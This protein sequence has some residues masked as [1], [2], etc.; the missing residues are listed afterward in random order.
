VQSF[1]KRLAR[2][3]HV[4]IVADRVPATPKGFPRVPLRVTCP[5]HERPRGPLLEARARL[6][7]IAEGAGLVD[8]ATL[9]LRQGLRRRLLGDWSND[10]DEGIVDAINR[11]EPLL[12]RPRFLALDGVERCDEAT[13]HLLRRAVSSPSWLRLPLLLVFRYVPTE[14][15]AAALAA[16]LGLDPALAVASTQEVPVEGLLTPRAALVLRAAA[17]VGPIFDVPAV[18]RLVGATPLEVLV[19][20]Q[21][22]VDAGFPLQDEADGRL[23]MPPE[24]ARDLRHGLLPSLRKAWG[25]SL[26]DSGREPAVTAHPSPAREVGPPTT[27]REAAPGQPAADVAPDLR[28]V[29]IEK[30]LQEAREAFLEGRDRKAL[31]LAARAV[32]NLEGLPPTPQRRMLRIE[33]YADLAQYK[34][35]SSGD[36]PGTRLADALV[37]AQGAEELLD[38]EDPVD[39]AAGVHA[40]VGSLCYDLGDPESL[41]TGLDAFSAAIRLLE[42]TGKP[43]EAA[44]LLND[45]AA[46]WIRL[47]DPVRATQLMRTS[48]EIFEERA[49]TD[50]EARIELAETD[51]LLARLPF[52]LGAR[53]GLETMAIETAIDHGERAAAAYEALDRIPELA[54]VWETL[55]RLELA[56]DQLETAAERLLEAVAVQQKIG[57]VL[58]LARTT[59]A[60]SD[61]LARADRIPEAL[62]LLADSIELNMRQGTPLGLAHNR[63]A[64]ETLRSGNGSDPRLTL[65]MDQIGTLLDRAQSIV[66]RMELPP[67]LR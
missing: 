63:H 15:P 37:L 60:L 30:L 3:E 14:G 9:R 47:G 5:A 44:R 57:D 1:W 49:E 19:D 50:P 27:Q 51:H 56:R 48:R 66:G 40:L 18:A 34:R 6:A 42:K 62:S 59:A 45:Q 31:T 7:R 21:E 12:E 38:A 22:A 43:V 61:G 35:E 10:A 65:A 20:L 17:T 4:G 32:A 11:A 58:G 36:A 39:L 26:L 54:R 2:G 23:S 64:L 33:L 67:Y 41:R 16:D 24:I 28:D 13:V 53:P 55:G 8:A 46:V 25:E 52:H 29:R